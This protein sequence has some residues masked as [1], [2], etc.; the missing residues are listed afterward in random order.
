VI[1]AF[2]RNMPYDQFTIEQLAGD[3][4]PDATVDQRIA[5]GFNRN[6]RI[7][8]EGGIIAEEWR[9]ESVIDRVETTGA[10]WLGLTLGCARCHDHKYDPVSQRDFYRLFA[11]F[12]SV[13]ETGTGQEK[14][15]NH[16]PFIKAPRPDEDQRLRELATAVAAARQRVAALEPAFTA[17]LAERERALLTNGDGEVGEGLAAHFAL[18]GDLTDAKGGWTTAA[19][20]GGKPEYKD[21]V[22]GK[23]AVFDGK[24]VI[25]A[26]TATDGPQLERDTRFSV[27]AWVKRSND[28]AMTVLSRMDDGKA[29]RGW[30]LFVHDGRLAM[31]LIDAWPD[32]AL[33]VRTKATLRTGEWLHVFA[34]YDGSGKAAGVRIFVDGLPVETEVEADTLSGSIAVQQP[35]RI[36]SRQ[37]GSRWKGQL[38][39]V[40]LYLRTLADDE[41]RRIA[42][43]PVRTIAGLAKRTPAQAKQL[44]TYLRAQAGGALVEADRAL[45]EA[46]RQQREYDER[47]P[48]VMVMEDLPKPR[49]AFILIRGEYDRHGDKV[50]PGTPVAFPPLKPEWPR[51][52]LGLA[53]WI[54]DPAN[55]LTAR[56]TANRIW[57]RLFGVGLVKTSENFG[58]QAD[59][60]S[61]RELLD[62]LASELVRQKWDLKA[63]HRLIVTSA[64]YRQSSVADPRQAQ[65]DPENRLLA[66]GPRFR[67]QAEI[68]RDQAMAIA[69]LLTERLGGPSVRPYQPPGI[70]DELSN[71]GNLHNYQVSPGDDLHRRSLY[72]IWKRTTPPPNV[73]LLDMPSREYC[74]VRRSRTNTPLQALTLMNDVTFVEAARVLAQR[75][76]GEG[77]T[78]AETRIAYGFRLATA[79]PPTAAEAAV[80]G[81][82]LARRLARFRADDA[83]AK[84]LIAQ[85]QAPMPAGLDP[86]ELAAF[87]MTASTILNLD[88]T[89]TKE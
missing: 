82:A 18:A 70:W 63:F 80:L 10:V 26:G 40:R 88:E 42:D 9:V 69:G 24:D 38:A 16:P 87:T 43:L 73:S 77:G 89:I 62:W 44:V 4:L 59:P 35:L 57:E 14:A 55:P 11:F 19:W 36:G 50:E 29:N 45:A 54:V 75:M 21:G 22:A 17:S 32:H 41:V 3:L 60:P 39:D 74:V 84:Q 25:V 20:Q 65:N 85:G 49:D 15:G 34:T 31:H 46:E 61:H 52:R 58:Q 7:N 56:V 76:L 64:T 27:G 1:D 83:A 81:A 86:A 72:T 8:T 48:T 53:R 47:V 30:D 67:L 51:N 68:I 79:R 23:A 5:T 12:N 13:S 37:N 6:H 71:Y 33:K 78:S 28:E 66:R 2:N